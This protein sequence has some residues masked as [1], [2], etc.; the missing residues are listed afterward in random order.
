MNWFPD[1]PDPDLRA[2]PKCNLHSHL[3]GSIRPATFLDLAR[4]RG[5]NL[6][7]GLEGVGALLQVDGSETGLVDYLEKISAGYQV[8]TTP[9]ALRRVAFEAA[10]DA[11]RDGVLYFELRA[12]PLTHVNRGLGVHQ[13]IDA[14]LAG[15]QHAEAAYGITCRLIIA[16]LRHHEPADNVALAHAAV[17]HRDDGVVGFDLAGDE[18]GYAASSHA[19]AF[20]VARRGGLG[21]TVHAGEAGGAENVRYA[22]EA[23]GAGRIGHGVRSAG[24]PAMMRLLQERGV[25]LEVCPASNVH[26]RT[27]ASL[28][29]HPVRRLFDAGVRVTIGDDDPVTS[30]TSVSKELTLLRDVFGFEA[31]EIVRIQKMGLEAAFGLDGGRRRRIMAA[32]EAHV[33]ASE[34]G[35]G[36]PVEPRSDA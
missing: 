3:E 17:E 35:A 11:A 10:E 7:V 8:L 20:A 27:V 6:G 13:A 14:I 30:D 32:L 22:V 1:R 19:D 23:L 25:T 5:L 4:E 28:A 36:E 26:T 34:P 16:A 29:A 21:I 2:L 9:S 24:S 12:G 33:L 15:L 31:A 18:A